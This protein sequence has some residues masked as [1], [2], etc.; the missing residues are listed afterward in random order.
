MFPWRSSKRRRGGLYS[1][2]NIAAFVSAVAA[3]FIFL[4][5]GV[6]QTARDLALNNPDEESWQL[7]MTVSASVAGAGDNSALFETWASDGDT[8]RPSPA[9]PTAA[10]RCKLDHGL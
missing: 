6:A 4:G 7:F 9:G 1:V 2:K 3:S 8:F 10:L 5:A